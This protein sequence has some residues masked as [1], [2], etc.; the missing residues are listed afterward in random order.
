M[1]KCMTRLLV[2]GLACV[3]VVSFA[4]AEW[5][6][7]VL[8]KDEEARWVDAVKEH[9]TLE[10]TTVSEVLQFVEKLRPRELKVGEIAAG[11]NTTGNP[12]GVTVC[13]WIGLKR[14]PDDA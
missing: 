11:Y 4:A 6:A 5:K 7:K 1:L 10:G 2:T 14:L 3:C 12:G 9:K 8:P 13:F